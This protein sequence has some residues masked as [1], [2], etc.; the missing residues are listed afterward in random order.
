MSK[1]QR[2]HLSFGIFSQYRKYL[3]AAGLFGA[4]SALYLSLVW[5]TS[6]TAPLYVQLNVIRDKQGA[7]SSAD[8]DLITNVV[9]PSNAGAYNEESVL[10]A[11]G[12]LNSHMG[13]SSNNPQLQRLLFA[14]IEQHEDRNAQSLALYGI[15][16]NM[17]EL[18][19]QSD[20][21]T[22]GNSFI[23]STHSHKHILKLCRT[24]LMQ[25]SNPNPPSV[26]NRLGIKASLSAIEHLGDFTDLQ[27]L[28]KFKHSN[29]TLIVECA[30]DAWIS[31]VSRGEKG[32]SDAG[33]NE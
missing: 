2:N 4:A 33:K 21:I 32:A 6:K 10:A 16:K 19:K 9:S 13:G 17:P 11:V 24:Y 14:V 23:S 25:Q 5:T 7:L 22:D 27:I 12:A 29:N 26:E 28:E 30:N 8:M 1:Q 20:T 3:I 15:I 18:A 31:V